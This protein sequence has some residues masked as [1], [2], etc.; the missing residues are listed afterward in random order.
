MNFLIDECLH[1]T[2]AQ[3]A[4][5]RGHEATHVTYRGMA[6]FQDWN[7]MAPIR[8]GLFTFVTN[9]ARDFR[10]LFAQEAVHAGLLI[11]VPNLPPAQQRILFDAIL[12]DIE[13]QALMNEVVEISYVDGDPTITRYALPR[14]EEGA[15]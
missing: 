6:G 4:V 8:E 3:V 5:A 14:D 2:L 7:L 15:N 1:T 12:D 13:G 9:N 10:R 11:I